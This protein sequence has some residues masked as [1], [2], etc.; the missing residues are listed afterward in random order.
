MG[1]FQGRRSQLEEHQLP[2]PQELQPAIPA[3]NDLAAQD[4][5]ACSASKAEQQQHQ[6][7]QQDSSEEELAAKVAADAGTA[8]AMLA[9]AEARASGV[10]Q[11]LGRSHDL[12]AG[13]EGHAAGITAQLPQLQACPHP[14]LHQSI[15]SKFG[16]PHVHDGPQKCNYISNDG[17]SRV[18]GGYRPVVAPKV[19]CIFV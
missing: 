13:L 16:P 7:Q 17:I 3:S 11:R 14:C 15:L 12:V 19:I 9:R 8:L 2:L 6:K 10:A 18:A 5:G 4:A 1:A